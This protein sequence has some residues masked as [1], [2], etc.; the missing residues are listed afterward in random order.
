MTKHLS[1]VGAPSVEAL[2]PSGLACLVIVARQH[3]LHLTP[4]Q[5]IHDNL[6]GDQEVTLAELLK[7]ANSSGM[8]A[9]AV[10]LDW[11][12]LSHLKRALPVI[13]RLRDG[14]HMVLLRLEGEENSSRVVLQDPNASEDALLVIDQP[15]FEDI[16]S[17]DVVMAK[18]DYEISDETQPF[19]FGF[20]TALLFRERRILR[21][22]AIAALILGFMGLGPIMFWRLLSDKVIFYKAYNTFYVLCIAML[23]LIM[24]EAAF[25]F[26][27]Q[28]LVQRLTARLDVKLSTYVFEKVLNLPID[29]FEQNAVGLISR[30]IREVFRIRGFLTGQLFGTILDSTTLF[31]FLPVMFFFSPIMTLM[32]L[33]FAGVIVTWLVLMLPAYRK[34]SSATLAAEG[35]QGA[36]LIQSLNGMRTIKSLALDTR[37]RHMWDVLVARVAKARLAEGLTGTAIQTVVR[38]LERLAVSAPYAFGVYMAV[39]SGDPVY[40]GAL[41]AF[42]M[43]SQRVAGPLM[44][45]AQLINQYDEARTAVA[46]VGRLVNQPPEEGRSGHGVRV[47]LKGL[48]EFSGVTFKY[49]GAVSP[50]LNNI[51]FEIPLGTTL[52]V[53]GKSGSG[54]TTITR[55]L[56]RLHSDYGG[57]IKVDGIDVREYDV[58]HLRRNVGVVLQENFLFSGTIRENISAAK[59]DAT[60][61]DIVRAAR[62]AGAE[63][64]IDKLPRGYETYIYEGST[65]LSGGQR[66]RLAIA[67]ALIVNPPILILDEATSALD[68]ESETIVNANIS[69]IAQ[70]RTLI[71]IS[72]RLSSLTKADAILVLNR[73]VVNDIGRHEELLERNDIYSSLWYQQNTHLVPAGRNEKNFRSPTLV[74]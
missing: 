36:F 45:M 60:F 9:K 25:T 5:L 38:P 44:Q 37:Q 2:P 68:A 6:L 40:V 48:V 15:R 55:L 69:R 70:G 1:L 26:L 31:F 29:Y 32:V 50:A 22:V 17:G 72:H 13:V 73:G 20:V 30:D 24:F 67:R 71:I 66:Q 3:G 62:L 18:R 58:D 56:Q 52:G 8:T 46:I 35:A 41:F 61:D 21:D 23:V 12:G 16:W 28:Y 53:M 10:S 54:K 11:K 19:S 64:F 33:G 4:S 65:N 14:S 39:S 51:S 7:C 43:L 34:K 42:L 59:P 63:E 47:P 27:R 49:K 74:S 57:L